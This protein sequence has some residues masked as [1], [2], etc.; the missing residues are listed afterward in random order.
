MTKL[1]LMACALV[2]LSGSLAEAATATY[3]DTA[4]HYSVSFD[5]DLW[6][7][8]ASLTGGGL[9]IFNAYDAAVSGASRGWKTSGYADSLLN[10]VSFTALD[11]Y[12]I[13]SITTGVSGSYSLLGSAH[14]FVQNAFTW[15]TNV[16]TDQSGVMY[17]KN[18]YCDGCSSSPDVTVVQGTSGNFTVNSSRVFAAGT[19][20][21]TFSNVMSGD[22]YAYGNTSSAT[23]NQAF[24]SFNV[25]TAPV[26]EPESYAMLLAGLGVIAGVARRQKPNRD[27][28]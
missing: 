20:F 6:G 7:S 3:I 14:A 9:N 13:S 19:S 11:G 22:V 28:A 18:L 8:S 1:K 26:P 2:A 25:V 5:T 27:L 10:S 4:N 21:A 12:T 16:S 15:N 23:L 24:T 17:L